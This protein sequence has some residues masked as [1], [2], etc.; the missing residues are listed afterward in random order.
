VG[1]AELA[2]RVGVSRQT[3]YAIEAGTYVPNTEVSLRLARELHVSIEQIFSLSESREATPEALPTRILSARPPAPGQPA[4][5]CRIGEHLISVP[6][7]A[8]PCYIPEADGVISV[9]GQQ[10][11]VAQVVPFTTDDPARKR[12]ILAGCDP[13]TSL[14][15][16]TVEATTGIEIVCAAASSKLALSWLAEGVIHIAGSH[17]E[18]PE[19]GEFN[20]PYLRRQFPD[21]DFAVITFAE[22]EEGF[23]TAA[24]NPKGISRAE[25][26]ANRRIRFVN[27]ESGSGSR[28]LLDRLL[29]DA[30]VPAT[31]VRGYASAVYG[32]LAAAHSV[33]TGTADCCVATRSAARTFGLNFV[34]LRRER[35]DLI[36]RR[37]TLESPR[38]QDFLDVLQRD[39]LRRKLEILAGY[40][41][42]RTG[43]VRA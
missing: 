11:A 6:V 12:L 33:L 39:A 29:G 23:V 3:I 19:T 21:E 37:E 30:G 43:T 17:L 9:T 38:V 28:S 36:L 18:D 7:T 42:A 20:L 22:W 2:R 5:L 14:L 8:S 16:A 10:A 25:H 4:R 34:P 41:T 1:A 24:G 31:R 15:A 27:R 35:Y 26:L 40:D 32:H 13:A